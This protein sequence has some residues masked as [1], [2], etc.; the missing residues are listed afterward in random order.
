MFRPIPE[1]SDN[2]TPIKNLYATGVGFPFG[3]GASVGE[4]YSCYKIIAEDFGLAKP[5]LEPGKEEPESLYQ[6]LQTLEKGLQEKAKVE[7]K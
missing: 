3:V 7:V 4:S 1:L 2:R 6:V 5:W